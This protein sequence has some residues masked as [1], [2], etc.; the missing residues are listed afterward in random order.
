MR[1]VTIGAGASVPFIVPLPP[2]TEGPGQGENFTNGTRQT[3]TILATI[4]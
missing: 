3:A 2:K 1:Y 4:L